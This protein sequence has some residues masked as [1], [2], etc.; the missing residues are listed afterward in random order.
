MG[1]TLRLGTTLRRLCSERG[2]LELE[3]VGDGWGIGDCLDEGRNWKLFVH[4][5]TR[6]N[7]TTDQDVSVLGRV[8]GGQWRNL[9][10]GCVGCG[11]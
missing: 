10:T 2:Y 8:D 4:S 5:H 7:G 11:I 6:W 9:I 3:L 1:T